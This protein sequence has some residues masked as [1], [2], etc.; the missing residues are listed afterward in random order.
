MLLKHFFVEKI[1]HSSYILA[2]GRACAVVDPARDPEMYLRFAEEQGLRITHILETHLHADF[3]SGHIDLARMTGAEIIAPSSA[4]CVFPHRGVS[5]G[6]SFMLENMRIDVLETPGHTP[7]HVSYVVTDTSR[8]EDPAGVFC[9]DT[10]F[11]GDAGRPDLFPGR[12]EELAGKL[13]DSLQKL[14]RLPDFCEVYPAHGAGSLCGRAVGAKYTSTLG[15]ERRYN[16]VLKYRREGL[17]KSMTTNMPPAP[18]HFSRCS[19]INRRGPLPLMEPGS[20]RSM[21]PEEFFHHST[22]PDV[23][24]VDARSCDGFSSC[25]IPN[26]LNISTLGNFPTFAGWVLDPRSELLIVADSPAHAAETIKAANMVGE[27]RVS[28]YLPGGLF[29]W[30]MHGLPCAGFRQ[31]FP[32]DLQE[33]LRSEEPF[34]L[35][36]VRAPGEYASGTIE[37]A[38]NIPAPDMRTR[39]TELDRNKATVLF[40]SSGHRSSFAASIL[41]GKGFTGLKH[42]SGGMAAWK[43]VVSG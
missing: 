35:V 38:V 1:A 12:A 41:E 28:G 39:H 25:H 26:S 18:D 5:E 15:Y 4:N 9:G 23:V 13:F 40:C 43:A 42:L 19:E 29:S 24:V 8:G 37:N 10:L 27:Y 22:R 32:G 21:T 3:L 6:D 30:A 14:M 17:V 36:D 33:M 11:V 34:T 16:E 31:I 2:G 7:E 20:A